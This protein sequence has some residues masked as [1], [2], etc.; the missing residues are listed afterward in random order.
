ME[1][2]PDVQETIVVTQG[3]IVQPTDVV[4]TVQVGQTDTHLTPEIFQ[5]ETTC[6]SEKDDNVP[7]PSSEVSIDFSNE[8]DTDTTEKRT[9][10][11]NVT[12]VLQHSSSERDVVVQ[13]AQK[14]S[15][16]VAS[17]RFNI[18][19][20]TIRSWMQNTVN[21]VPSNPKFN[22]PGQGRKIS[23]SKETDEAI[24]AYFK[25][26]VVDGNNDKFTVQD[27][28][29]FAKDLVQKENPSFNASTGW[30]YRF[31]SRHNL[32]LPNSPRVRT[33][34]KGDPSI[35]YR[36]RPLSY[37]SSTDIKIAEWV[38]QQQA[39]GVTLS[40]TQL[41]N[42]ARSTITKEN[43]NFTASASWCQNFLLRHRLHLNNK[44]IQYKNES[45]AKKLSSNS[46]DNSQ[47]DDSQPLGF[48]GAS[49]QEPT[50]FQDASIGGNP[51]DSED[52]R[53]GVSSRDQEC[54][55]IVG[56][57]SDR[58]A[59]VSASSSLYQDVI[60]TNPTVGNMMDT[61]YTSGT[62]SGSSDVALAL[63]YLN[64][65][66]NDVPSTSQTAATSI[67]GSML[68]S[69]NVTSTSISVSDMVTVATEPSTGT[70]TLGIFCSSDG[71]PI[72]PTGTS[73][74]F[75]NPENLVISNLIGADGNLLDG[76]PGSILGTGSHSLSLTSGVTSHLPSYPSAVN[77]SKPLSYATE[78]DNVL[79]EWVTKQQSAGERVTFTKLRGYAKQ[80]IQQENP[81]FNASVGWVTPFLLRHNLDLSKNKKKKSRS[82]AQFERRQSKET[83]LQDSE[84]SLPSDTVDISV[85]SNSLR[86]E[87]VTV[88]DQ[89]ASAL[90]DS[91]K[92][93]EMV[94]VQD[95]KAIDKETPLTSGSKEVH[96]QFNQVDTSGDSI[97]KIRASAKP[98]H[99]LSE[100][101]EVVNLMRAY[102]TSLQSTSRILGVAVSTLCGWVKMMEQKRPQIEAMFSKQGKVVNLH[103]AGRP[104]SYS[105]EK[106]KQIAQW[107]ICQQDTG[108]HLTAK[109]VCQYAYSVIQDENPNFVASISWAR[110]FLKRHNLKLANTSTRKSSKQASD[111]DRLYSEV[112][113]A[114]ASSTTGIVGQTIEV[115]SSEDLSVPSSVVTPE[116]SVSIPDPT[117]E[118]GDDISQLESS[119]LDSITV[120]E[121]DPSQVDL[122]ALEK[123]EYHISPE[124]E[125]Y[126]VQWTREKVSSLGCLSIQTFCT[127]AEELIIPTDR[128]FVATLDWAFRFLHK[129]SLQ[130]EPRPMVMESERKRILGEDDSVEL[131]SKAMCFRVTD[132]S[133][134]PSSACEVLFQLPDNQ[135]TNKGKEL[136][137]RPTILQQELA[138]K[139]KAAREFSTAEK[140]EV[141]KYANA[142]TLQKAA[143][144]YGVAAPTVWRWRLEL[145]LNSPRYTIE[146]KRKITNYASQT[147]LK[148]AA[149]KFGLS[150]KT[151]QNWR[152]MFNSGNTS[153]SDSTSQQDSLDQSD[154]GLTSLDIPS[155]T[156]SL[157]HTYATTTAQDNPVSSIMDTEQLINSCASMSHSDSL[158]SS[159]SQTE[160]IMM[161][162]ECDI[163]YDIATDTRFSAARQS[164]AKWSLKDK[165]EIL[166]C[167]LE[168]SIREAGDKF[169]LKSV[170]FCNWQKLSNS[171]SQ[172]SETL[173]GSS[174][175][176][177]IEN[178]MI[179]DGNVAADV[180]VSSSAGMEFPVSIVVESSG[181]HSGDQLFPVTTSSGLSLSSTEPHQFMVDTS[182]PLV[183]SPT[184]DT[185][186]EVNFR[187]RDTIQQDH[188]AIVVDQQPT[189]SNQGS[190]NEC[191]LLDIQ[192]H[193]LSKQ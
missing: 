135:N 59:S 67:A 117:P 23:Y 74:Q 95:F 119:Q 166:K 144:K 170:S 138:E 92:V 64:R 157:D 187:L 123:A 42:F 22:S 51:I 5:V 57:T 122:A 155:Q 41:R 102:G 31:L 43:P 62:N 13:F 82:I 97:K 29:R 158:P 98:R 148:E 25:E 15:L 90:R 84:D 188:N 94:D 129:H 58:D 10:Q 79:A 185:T 14:Y 86:C 183:T 101:I 91:G 147:S 165:V 100:K 132:S 113:T 106:D 37:S 3:S 40:N 108:T 152:K 103:G 49:W 30:A 115:V 131:A 81:H 20:T 28:C 192:D 173:P 186:S 159:T 17:K 118:G 54:L 65:L 150:T 143:M 38:R 99:T 175:E 63:A 33:K 66:T 107:V 93:V 120:T 35:D 87:L 73:N 169:G 34:K 174:E 11:E 9:L 46:D 21:S 163:E 75:I 70:D 96:Q 171:G 164:I 168:Q 137:D 142:F 134:I 71:P 55:G 177:V 126:L 172:T 130:L 109:E 180:I 128:L 145:K 149:G 52:G 2:I 139:S 121:T 69:D 189:F 47:S 161:P 50:G 125:T 53:T 162:Q 44:Y 68:F 110:K 18:P 111:D 176:V 127:Y 27:L 112:V 19:R 48:F 26:Q 8:V 167:A 83:L 181:G 141:V 160:V 88:E 77:T 12:Y 60:V 105:E 182:I 80:L 114:N 4:V 6:S 89:V 72:T 153:G 16:S 156:Y 133:A 154:L 116:I 124:I 78:T 56:L 191:Q 39:E 24:V 140:E 151:I 32:L 146:Q 104:L 45:A 184:L 61:D 179:A 85:P 193:S 136:G 36:G 7:I 76:T 190:T 1:G 178:S